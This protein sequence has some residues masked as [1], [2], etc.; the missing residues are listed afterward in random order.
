MSTSLKV[1]RIAAV[2]CA[3][4][5]RSAIRSRMRLIGTARSFSPSR[6]SVGA[7]M[8]ASAAAGGGSAGAGVAGPAP[9]GRGARRRGGGGSRR[10]RRAGR[11]AV[12]RGRR[13]GGGGARRL[14]GR[15]RALL[16]PGQ[17]VPDLDAVAEGA[18]VMEDAG[19]LARDLDRGLVGL[20]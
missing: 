4:T 19:E 14:G 3:L 8:G 10:L 2:C 18:G 12:A 1:V 13:R 5:R 16:H 6:Q 9:G 7:R 15:R 20:E 17:D 11:A